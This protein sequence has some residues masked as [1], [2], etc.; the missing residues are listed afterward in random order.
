MAIV[1]SIDQTVEG[2]PISA[3]PMRNSFSLLTRTVRQEHP[4]DE[5]E[6]NS[7]ITLISPPQRA[8]T[9]AAVPISLKSRTTVQIP[10]RLCIVGR[11]LSAANDRASRELAQPTRIITTACQL[12]IAREHLSW[13]SISEDMAH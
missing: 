4:F 11:P 12:S 6:Q 13:P 10:A 9:H 2:L 8:L 7:V 1:S 5:P 3:F